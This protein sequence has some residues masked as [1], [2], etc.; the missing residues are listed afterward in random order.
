MSTP[1]QDDELP[2][3]G[4]DDE[5]EVVQETRTPV[6]LPDGPDERSMLG[7]MPKWLLWVVVAGLVLVVA[8][9]AGALSGNL[10]G[11]GGDAEESEAAQVEE[12]GA[13]V[14]VPEPGVETSGTICVD[15]ANVRGGPGTE[16]DIV[17]TLTTGDGVLYTAV[18]GTE[19][20][21]QL[22]G[23]QAWVSTDLLCQE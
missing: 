4:A 23:A 21:V 15:V 2:P 8:I 22:V 16:H 13:P 7:G 19:G 6:E 14:D 1:T 3:Y 18:E 11:L 12:G 17:N 5:M 9:V 10:P 20:W